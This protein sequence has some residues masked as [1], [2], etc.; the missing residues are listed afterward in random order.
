MYWS[1]ASESVSTRHLWPNLVYIVDPQEDLGVWTPNTG[2][3]SPH[4][5]ASLPEGI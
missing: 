3:Q 5:D 4:L 1:Q 2:T